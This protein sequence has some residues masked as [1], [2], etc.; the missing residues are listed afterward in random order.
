MKDFIVRDKKKNTTWKAEVEIHIAI[1]K[2]IMKIL[3]LMSL[4]IGGGNI[5]VLAKKLRKMAIFRNKLKDFEKTIRDE[6]LK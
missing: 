5:S 2:K 4:I 3:T 1:W 6:A